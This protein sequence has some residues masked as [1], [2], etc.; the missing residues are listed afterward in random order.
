MKVFTTAPSYLGCMNQHLSHPL[1]KL[2]ETMRT[3]ATAKGDQRA[4]LRA[5]RTELFAINESELPS[6]FQEPYAAIVSELTK[7]E[8]KDDEGTIDA[9]LAHIRNATAVQIIE[10]IWEL[11][12]QMRLSVTK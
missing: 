8:A 9:T 6:D 2:A 7:F 10:S 12:R 1:E 4:R 3:I 11:W 5:A